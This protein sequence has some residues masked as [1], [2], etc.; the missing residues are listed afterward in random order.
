MTAPE[1]IRDRSI[2]G[3]FSLQVGHTADLTAAVLARARDLLDVVFSGDLTDHDWEHSLGG[4][5]SIVWHNSSVVG[6][7][8]VIQRRLVHGDQVLRAGYVEGVGVHP[9]WQRHGIGGQMMAALERI[10]DSAYDIGALGATDEAINLYEHRGWVRWLGPTSAL[11]PTGIVRTP[12]DDGC[13]YVFPAT[14]GLDVG[15]EL[16]CDWRDGDVW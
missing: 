14:H 15:G 9:E 5:H 1:Q 3:V 13:I 16:T 10:I 4:M 6:H 8:S 2:P 11:T 7:A 12:D